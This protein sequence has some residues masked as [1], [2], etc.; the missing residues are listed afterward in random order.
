[1]II[2]IM[3]LNKIKIIYNTFFKIFGI[4]LNKIKKKIQIV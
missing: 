3:K 4:N 1:M 2:G